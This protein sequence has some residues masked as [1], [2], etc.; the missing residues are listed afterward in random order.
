MVGKSGRV[1]LMDSFCDAH[2]D[3]ARSNC[4]ID[5]DED[6]KRVPLFCVAA[7]AR[8]TRIAWAGAPKEKTTELAFTF[9]TKRPDPSDLFI[10][11]ARK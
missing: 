1:R 4:F 9:A 10:C 7:N 6:G 8:G 5:S 3:L 2:T 11:T